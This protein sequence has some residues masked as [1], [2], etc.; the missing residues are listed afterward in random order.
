MNGMLNFPRCPF[1]GGTSIDDV[2]PADG[3]LADL[4][5]FLCTVC[6]NGWFTYSD[7]RGL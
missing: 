2:P 5:S 7:S 6:S 1:C 4:D 3:S